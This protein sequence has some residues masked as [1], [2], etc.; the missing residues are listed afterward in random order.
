MG[1][2]AAYESFV[3]PGMLAHSKPKKVVIF[4]AGAG[5]SIREVLKHKDVEQVVLVG[6]E[7]NLVEFSKQHLQDWN[8]CSGVSCFDDSRVVMAEK[9]EF[10]SAFDVAFVD[11][12]YFASEYV[13]VALIADALTEKG[14]A[15]FHISNDRPADLA[16]AL[17]NGS[18]ATNHRESQNGFI[19]SLGQVGFA[20]TREYAEKQVGFPEPRKYVVAFKSSETDATNWSRNEAEVNTEILRRTTP[21]SGSSP[22][23]F[24]DGAKM[25]SYSKYVDQKSLD[26]KALPSP[27]VC[28]SPHKQNQE[29]VSPH[30]QNQENITDEENTCDGISGEMPACNFA[31]HLSS[32]PWKETLIVS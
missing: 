12:A 31:A 7:R 16:V 23:Q 15:T 8:D 10:A 24:F 14:V 29:N 22:F 4:G 17:P 28:V 18:R 19:T 26:C 20:A 32:Y 11:L 5:G 27:L 9:F 3:H 13:N 2:S 30:Q 21:I 6:V 1:E 25:S